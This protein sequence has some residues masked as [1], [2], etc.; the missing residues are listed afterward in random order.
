MI[1]A[2]PMAYRWQPCALRSTQSMPATSKLDLEPPGASGL[3]VS[4]LARSCSLFQAG[5]MLCIAL[6]PA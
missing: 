2:A 3:P 1:A 5:G 4:W 6:K